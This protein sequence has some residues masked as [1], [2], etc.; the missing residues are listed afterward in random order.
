MSKSNAVNQVIITKVLKELIG[1]LRN[2][3]RN[4]SGRTEIV[5]LDIPL[6]CSNFINNETMDEYLSLLML[7]V[8]P[9]FVYSVLK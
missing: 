8:V 7:I 4:N 6:K 5:N 1:F 3:S 2:I 9:E